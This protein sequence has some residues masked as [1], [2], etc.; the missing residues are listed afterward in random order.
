MCCVCVLCVLCCAMRRAS[1][2]IQ[3]EKH[4]CPCACLCLRFCVRECVYLFVSYLCACVWAWLSLCAPR[5][6]RPRKLFAPANSFIAF[7]PGPLRAYTNSESHP[8]VRH[9]RMSAMYRVSYYSSSLSRRRRCRH[10]RTYVHEKHPRVSRL[11]VSC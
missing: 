3:E 4:V 10:V 5:P 9:A 7:H 8:Q 11:A 6:P 2:H 1:R